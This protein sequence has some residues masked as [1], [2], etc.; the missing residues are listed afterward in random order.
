[1]RTSGGSFAGALH[2]V[3][4]QPR[5]RH[6]SRLFRG[7][8]CL[9]EADRATDGSPAMNNAEEGKSR[10][11]SATILM[12]DR[13][14]GRGGDGKSGTSPATD[15]C[16]NWTSVH[17][18]SCCS[19]CTARRSLKGPSVSIA[20]TIRGDAAR[21][22]ATTRDGGCDSDEREGDVGGETGSR[23]HSCG[24]QERG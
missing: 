3:R 6:G 10:C 15:G 2:R 14:S 18:R 23:R 24:W 19:W 5:P 8:D 11:R 17:R 20:L 4:V 22:D 1:M 16:R 21:D 12:L 13:G 9:S 7:G